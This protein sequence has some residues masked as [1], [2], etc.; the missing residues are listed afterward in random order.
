M[1]ARL[2]RFPI[3]C[4]KCKTDRTAVRLKSRHG[5]SRVGFEP[6]AACGSAMAYRVTA[7]S[8]AERRGATA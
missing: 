6:C 2:I 3:R 4:A 1:A 8:V 7:A 5:F